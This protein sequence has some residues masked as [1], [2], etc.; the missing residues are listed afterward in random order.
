MNRSPTYVTLDRPCSETEVSASHSSRKPR[1]IVVTM[2]KHFDKSNWSSARQ[3]HMNSAPTW[4]T[5][6]KPAKS[7]PVTACES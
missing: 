1:S 4:A 6:R 7:T 5:R 2:S 3:P